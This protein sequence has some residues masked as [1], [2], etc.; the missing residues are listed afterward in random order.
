MLVALLTVNFIASIALMVFAVFR[1]KRGITLL[2]TFVL[3]FVLCCCIG[4]S[5][6]EPFAEFLPPT[7]YSDLALARVVFA[8]L[9]FMCCG[10][11]AL[12]IEGKVLGRKDASRANFRILPLSP[13][14]KVAI[15]TASLFVTIF[16]A[17]WLGSVG[18]LEDPFAAYKETGGSGQYYKYR[19]LVE[20]DVA[21]KGGRG[22]WTAKKLAL[23]V[24]PFLMILLAYLFFR[25]MN[26]LYLG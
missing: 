20:E 19:Q 26:W 4:V 1:M 5:F 12:A 23:N 22:S 2:N 13:E 24:G 18:K 9:L 17:V 14:G 11:I 15:M 10:A 6:F 7:Q 8:N 3:I 25:T 21:G 16:L